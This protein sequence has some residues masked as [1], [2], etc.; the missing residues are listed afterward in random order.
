[1]DRREA[2]EVAETRLRELRELSYSELLRRYSRDEG[3]ESVWEEAEGPSGT[4]YQ[5]KL[6]AFWDNGPPN[7]R[8][9]VA[10]DDGTRWSFM[11]PVTTTFIIQPDGSFVGE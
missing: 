10:A 3:N 9:W 7:L 4:R 2:T 11:R 5:L 6:E 1:V 8:V